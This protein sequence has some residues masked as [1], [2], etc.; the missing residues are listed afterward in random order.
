MNKQKK[1]GTVDSAFPPIT[2]W[3]S[4]FSLVHLGALVSVVAVCRMARIFS[5]ECASELWP[6]FASAVTRLPPSLKFTSSK[7]AHCTARTRTGV[8]RG[9]S[10]RRLKVAGVGSPWGEA[11]KKAESFLKLP[12]GAWCLRPW[13]YLPEQ[14]SWWICER[15]LCAAC[16]CLEETRIAPLNPFNWTCLFYKKNIRFKR[17]E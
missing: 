7:F 13:G 17:Y 2:V 12:V 15:R 3:W 9:A 6:L 8:A 1:S 10:R 4:T 11:R 5:L 16:E 14:E